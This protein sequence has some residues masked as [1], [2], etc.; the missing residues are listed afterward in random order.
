MFTRRPKSRSSVGTEYKYQLEVVRE[1]LRCAEVA[2]SGDK[3]LPRSRSALA[4]K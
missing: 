2:F 4:W 1:W 3:Y